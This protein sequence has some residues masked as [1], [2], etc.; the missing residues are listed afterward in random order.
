M[1]AMTKKTRASSSYRVDKVGVEKPSYFGIKKQAVSKYNELHEAMD[2]VRFWPC[3]DNPYFYTDYDNAGFEDDAG[4]PRLLTDDQ[5]EELCTD[6]PLIKLCYEF[7]VLNEEQYGVWGGINFAQ[8]Q[9]IKKLRN[10][11]EKNAK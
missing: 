5:C 11:K 1:A 10:E 4:G 3:K 6:C 2:E 8:T 9:Q 7:A